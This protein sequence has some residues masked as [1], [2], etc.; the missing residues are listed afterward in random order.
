MMGKL[1]DRVDI[2]KSGFSEMEKA[3]IKATKHNTKPPKEKHVRRLIV[4]NHEQSHR[5]AELINLLAKRLEV[6]DWIVV[7]KTLIT[8]HRLLRDSRP[9][10]ISEM[11]YRSAIFN[12]RRFAD[13]SSPEAHHQ[14]IFI[15]KY[16]QYL[17]EKVLVF[18]IVNV[19]FEKD[20]TATKNM[21]VEESFEK[22]PRLQSQLNA[23]LNCRASKDHINNNIIATAFTLLL[24]DSFKLYSSLN[25]GIINILENYFN[26]SKANATKSLEIYKLFTKETDGIIQFFEISKRFSRSDLPE[27]QHA[28]TTLVEALESY[29]KDLDDGKSPNATNNAVG[30]EK[31]NMVKAQ[32]LMNKQMNDFKF[33]DD[34]EDDAASSDDEVPK[35]DASPSQNK[36]PAASPFDPF[37]GGFGETDPFGK[38]SATFDP[39]A[40]TPLDAA[41]PVSYD[42]KKKQ[43]E[44]LMTTSSVHPTTAMTPLSPTPLQPVTFPAPTGFPQ[45]YPTGFPAQNAF[46]PSQGSP[47]QQQRAS[48]PVNQ[49]QQ[50]PVYNNPFLQPTPPNN[51]P[52]A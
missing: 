20:P 3:V 9:Q 24:K 38:Q 45:Q 18:K 2:I 12:L 27:L 4:Y 41:P 50:A 7:T 21:T 35:G 15:R 52:F 11:R 47:A 42:V 8:F 43:I 30:T 37:G 40:T 48:W 39:F 22:I 1:A 49:P 51:N 5:I 34:P 36:Q 13:M 32:E 23:L 19:E 29:I 26:M 44:T 31:S 6:P 28:P 46:P 16:A 10:F 17:E 14:S 25:D 33:D